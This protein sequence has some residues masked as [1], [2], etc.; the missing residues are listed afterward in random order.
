M[1][2][3]VTVGGV[4]F[5]HFEPSCQCALGRVNKGL[6]ELGDLTFIEL[7]WVGVLRVKRNR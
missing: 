5:D 1:M 4:Y 2:Q 7:P 3:Q 6:N